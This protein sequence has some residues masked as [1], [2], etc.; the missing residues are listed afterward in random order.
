[1]STDKSDQAAD[2]TIAAVRLDNRGKILAAIVTGIFGLI[3]AV[4]AACLG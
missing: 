1:M 2:E 4:L 3:A